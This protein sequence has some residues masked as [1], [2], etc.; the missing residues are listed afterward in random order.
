MEL[1]PWGVA[2]LALLSVTAS[3]AVATADT[4]RSVEPAPASA[5]K[6]AV[7]EPAPAPARERAVVERGI[8]LP[9][10]P[11]MAP[12]DEYFDGAD[13]DDGGDDDDDM[14]ATWNAIMQKTRPATAPALSSSSPPAPRSA[15][16]I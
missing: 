16:W 7:A 3:S 5:R 6:R 14:D 10:P 4:W 1:L 9:P 15:P 8:S 11:A 13:H 2:L 12:T